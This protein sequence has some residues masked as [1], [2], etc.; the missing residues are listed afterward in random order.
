[1]KKKNIGLQVTLAATTLTTNPL[2]STKRKIHQKH[3]DCLNVSVIKVVG[4]SN[5]GV[6]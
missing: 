6:Q 3:K 5:N 4:Y 2:P 1:M